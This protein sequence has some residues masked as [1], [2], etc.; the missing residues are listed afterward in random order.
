M[1]LPAHY[2]WLQPKTS[3]HHL[4]DDAWPNGDVDPH[5]GTIL[6]LPIVSIDSSVSKIVLIFIFM[7]FLGHS[8]F[9]LWISFNGGRTSGFPYFAI[10]LRI[11]QHWF[12]HI[13]NASVFKDFF[14]S[15]KKVMAD[16]SILLLAQCNTGAFLQIIPLSEHP[17]QIS[18]LVTISFHLYDGHSPIIWLFLN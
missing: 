2:Q 16:F 18:E 15:F 7:W 11:R 12:E 5:Y 1:V 14:A 4:L 6:P 17:W 13:R 8:I 3:H 9:F 10:V